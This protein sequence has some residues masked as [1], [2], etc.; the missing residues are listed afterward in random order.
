MACLQ[1][2]VFSSSHQNMRALWSSDVMMA[3]SLATLTP[4]WP[5]WPLDY[6]PPMVTTAEVSGHPTDGKIPS[7]QI[8]HPF[9]QKMHGLH[10]IHGDEINVK[11]CCIV[12]HIV[13]KPTYKLA[14]DRRVIGRDEEHWSVMSSQPV[15]DH[16]TLPYL[17]CHWHHWMGELQ[18]YWPRALS[19]L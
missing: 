16:E 5:A 3:S 19:H 13:Q 14:C 8:I 18:M 12:G 10:Y 17:W 9:L 4:S 11:R 6:G 1:G 15:I 2:V 7:V